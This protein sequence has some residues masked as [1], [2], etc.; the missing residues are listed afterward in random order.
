MRSTVLY[1]AYLRFLRPSLVPAVTLL[2]LAGCAGIPDPGL[3]PRTEPKLPEIT[4]PN[5]ALR[6]LP[7]PPKRVAVAV[8]GF[9]DLTGQFG[10]TE[11]GG[12]TLSRQVTQGGEALLIKAL[13]DAGERRWFT[14]LDRMRLDDTLKERQIITEMRRIYRNEDKPTADVLPPLAHAGIILQGGII[15]YDTY[16]QTGGFGARYLGIGAFTQWQHDTVE[17]TLRAVST[18]TGEVL[19]SVLARKDIVSVSLKGDVFRYVMLDRIVEAEAG[20]TRNEPTTVA[21]Q[22]AIE[23]VVASLVIEGA[24]RGLWTFGD[25]VTGR[26]LIAS[27][28]AEKYQAHVPPEVASTRR[29]HTSIP[30]TV[31]RRA[32]EVPAPVAPVPPAREAPRQPPQKQDGEVL[33]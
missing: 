13:Q 19:V 6:N 27:Y 25:A 21:V 24:E 31:A 14:V 10:E 23:K 4:T 29:V 3:G 26:E 7:P 33:G 18:R 2:G 1:S 20:V 30:R 8:Y 28:N 32:V 15:G 5:L 12:Q 16:K 11:A 9:P 17:V 22:E